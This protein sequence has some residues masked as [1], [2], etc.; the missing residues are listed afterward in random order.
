MSSSPFSHIPT[1]KEVPQES[2]VEKDTITRFRNDGQS[3]SPDTLSPPNGTLAGT[4]LSICGSLSTLLFLGMVP[5]VA[6]GSEYRPG[7]MWRV[8]VAFGIGF[9]LVSL[10]ALWTVFGPFRFFTRV[11]L[12]LLLVAFAMLA[13]SAFFLAN[14]RMGSQLEGPMLVSGAAAL[15]WIGLVV[16]F[17]VARA[18]VGRRLA[19]SEAS[20]LIGNRKAQFGIRQI[21]LWTTGVALF[22][23]VFRIFVPQFIPHGVDWSAV[24]RGSCEFGL[25]LGFN[26]VVTCSITAATLIRRNLIL[27]LT[28]ALFVLLVATWLEYPLFNLVLGG[29]GADSTIFWW[30]NA[31]GSLCLAVNLLIVRLSGYRLVP[32][33]R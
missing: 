7:D 25:L 3:L 20:P 24:S 16:L 32:D 29:G 21:L 23:A 2:A 31:A 6:I 8:G 30:I 5:L 22:L 27:R 15:Q 9:G 18:I 12:A 28:I 10:S 26:L 33:V 17:V 1:G 13:L 19:L 11:P 14:Q 4:I